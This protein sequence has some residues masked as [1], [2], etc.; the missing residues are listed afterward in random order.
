MTVRRPLRADAQRN[1]QRVLDV[2]EAVFAEQGL[3]VPIDEIARR[4]E[5]GIGTLYRHFPTKEALFAAIVVGRVERATL[6][7]VELARTEPAGEMFFGFLSYLL[8]Q[9]VSKKD[10]VDALAGAGVDLHRVAAPSKRA[11][12]AAFGK[13]LMRARATGAV[14]DDVTLDDVL[15]LVAG[16]FTAIERHPG[17]A[18]TRDHLL[19]ILCDGLRRPLQ[20]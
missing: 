9:G 10:F 19:A 14:R 6:H 7:A 5:L 20:G 17:P 12:R 2:A 16:L 18:R 3:D 4:A 1:R 15:A 8:A 13:L 11:F